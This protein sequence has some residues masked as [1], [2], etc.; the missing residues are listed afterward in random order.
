[1]T[2]KQ[3]LQTELAKHG[4]ELGCYISQA[5]KLG[6]RALNRIIEAWLMNEATEIVT[7]IKGAKYVIMLD[8]VDNEK[9][10]NIMTLNTYRKTFGDC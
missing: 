3:Y 2:N 4:W 7:S 6:K 10:I 8:T 5:E 1:M 9:D